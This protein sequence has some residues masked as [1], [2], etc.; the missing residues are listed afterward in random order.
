MSCAIGLVSDDGIWFGA[1]SAA[2]TNDGEIRPITAK[3]IFRNGNYL[4]AYIG[5]VRGGQI[6]YPEYFKPPKDITFLVDNIIEQCRKKE[7]LGIDAEY[8]TA[9]H[10]CNYLIAHKNT[11]YEI[12]VDFQINEISDYTAIGSGSP[13][14]FG[15]L[16]TTRKLKASPEQR[17]KLALAAAANFDTST[18]PPFV[19]E[20]L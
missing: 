1:D 14:A 5:S 12:L 7:C 19:I 17:I 8:Q 4:F 10:K 6:L 3:K 16:F 15:S 18:A 11:L 20:K 2:T 13:Y 9:V